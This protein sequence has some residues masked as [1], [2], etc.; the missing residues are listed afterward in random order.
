MHKVGDVLK[1][2]VPYTSTGKEPKCRWFVFFREAK[3]Y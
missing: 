1:V 2:T 3:F